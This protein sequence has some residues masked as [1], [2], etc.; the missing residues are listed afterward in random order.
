M[1]NNTEEKLIA[2]MEIWKTHETIHAITRHQ[3]T[4]FRLVEGSYTDDQVEDIIID[5]TCLQNI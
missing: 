2:L 1:G 4:L 3:T 5:K